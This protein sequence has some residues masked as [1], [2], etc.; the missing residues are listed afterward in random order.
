MCGC[1][2]LVTSRFVGGL[3][4]AREIE[5]DV[6]SKMMG[7]LQDSHVTSKIYQSSDAL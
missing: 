1:L 3:F 5:K 7:S 2:N 6:Y 4:V